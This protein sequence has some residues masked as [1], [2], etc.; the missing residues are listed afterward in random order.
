MMRS[1]RRA[2]LI[3]LPVVATMALR[4]YRQTLA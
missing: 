1:Q 3:F 2:V 4:R